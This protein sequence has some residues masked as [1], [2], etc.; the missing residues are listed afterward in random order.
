MIT[1]VFNLVSFHFQT[2]IPT[3]MIR[4]SPVAYKER[5]RPTS[6]ACLDSLHSYRE[7]ET[8]PRIFSDDLRLCLKDSTSRILNESFKL[9]LRENTQRSTLYTNSYS[10]VEDVESR[11]SNDSHRY[12]PKD[13]IHKIMNDSD[14]YSTKE[15]SPKIMNNSYRSPV[16]DRKTRNFSDNYRHAVSFP[17]SHLSRREL[18]LCTPDDLLDIIREPTGYYALP[19]DP[20][21]EVYPDVY[22][23]DA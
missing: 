20:W 18:P 17:D 10:P 23:S 5:R 6:I 9:P 11:I 14:K 22:L 15:N 12:S 7:K 21:N 19:T 13:R 3:P 4:R 8:V 1:F 2:R 16:K